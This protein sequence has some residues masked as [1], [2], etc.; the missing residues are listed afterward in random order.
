M[1]N[2]TTGN[3]NDEG[4]LEGPD[5][6]VTTADVQ[7]LTD[8][9]DGLGPDGTVPAA[10]HGIAAGLSSTPLHFNP[11]EDDPNAETDR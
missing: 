7:D 3:S 4:S 10:P 8:K 1:T 2:S 11:E 9:P 5:V 6:E